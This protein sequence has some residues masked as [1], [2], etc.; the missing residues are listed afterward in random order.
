MAEMKLWTVPATRSFADALA[1]GLIE[2]HPGMALARGLVLLPNNRGKRAVTEA[3]VRRS[4]GGL[5]LPRLVAMGD[6]ELGEGAGAVLDPADSEP[7]PPAVAPLA[8]RMALTRLLHE[9]RPNLD[10][11]E[12]VRLAGELARTLDQLQVEEVP[13]SRLAELDAELTPEL[14]AH[15]RKSLDL[16]ELIL[17]RWPAE[18]A[19]LG[20]VDAAARRGLVLDRVAARWRR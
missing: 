14:S 11:A 4:G 15:W 5:L 16:F 3:F 6:P 1:T 12:A 10:A 9:A 8:R 7:I 18:L 13:A 19:K 20:A 2:R 17:A